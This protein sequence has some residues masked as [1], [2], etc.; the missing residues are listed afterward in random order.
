MIE[1]EEEEEEEERLS[2]PKS[3]ESA[4]PGSSLFR[5]RLRLH[6]LTDF[7]IDVK[8]FRNASIKADGLSLV[9]ITFA[10]V[11]WNTFSGAGV[12]QTIVF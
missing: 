10:V 5:S 11:I 1:E 12:C 4:G 9:E 8:E 7:H 3:S 2:T 6:L